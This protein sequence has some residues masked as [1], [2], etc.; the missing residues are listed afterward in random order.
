MRGTTGLALSW[1]LSWFSLLLFLSAGVVKFFEPF[2]HYR[3]LVEFCLLITSVVL[4]VLGGEL[5]WRSTRGR[6]IGLHL[7]R[8][9][10]ERRS[11][12]NGR[13]GRGGR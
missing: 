6:T 7:R 1:L 11:R 4:F 2:A 5:H 8:R 9:R 12:M 13:G 10:G 3:G